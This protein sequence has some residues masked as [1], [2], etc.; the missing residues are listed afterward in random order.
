MNHLKILFFALLATFSAGLAIAQGAQVAFGG[1]QH[2]T[3]LPVEMSAD[4]LRIDQS[5]GTALFTGN[6]LIGQG[7]MRLSAAKVRVEYAAKNNDSTGRVSRLFAS[8]GVTLLSG[9]EAAEAQQAEYSIDSGVIVMTG[10]VILTQGRN[11][12]SSDKMTINLNTG[13]AAMGGR[14]KSILRTGEN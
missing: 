11:A 13:V 14:V 12:L 9:A 2:D 8:G 1:L 10:N 7:D 6:V 3:T 5:D 4:Q